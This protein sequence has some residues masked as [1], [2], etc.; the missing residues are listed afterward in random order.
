MRRVT[1]TLLGAASALPIAISVEPDLALGCVWWGM[2]GGGFPDWFDLRSDLRKPLRLRHR[3]A[4]HSVFAGLIA[5]GGLFWALTILM[6]T[7]FS[8]AGVGFAPSRDA[9]WLWSATFALG[10][11]SHLLGD[12]CTT[13][14]IRPLLPFSAA[15]C[16]LLPRPLRSRSDGF[17]DRIGRA[18]ALAAL[19]GGMALYAVRML[20]TPL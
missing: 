3:G 15:R 20:G 11:L 6:A 16:W 1:H 13:A 19:L 4:S 5:T 12:A 8:V 2:V 18:L 14:G 17:V 10:F 7:E 9:V